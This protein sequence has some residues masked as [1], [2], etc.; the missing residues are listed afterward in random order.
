VFARNGHA[1]P[2]DRLSW[3]DGELEDFLARAG[4][5]SRVML[6][7]SLWLVAVAAP[8]AFRRWARLEALPVADRVAA[9]AALERALPEPLLAVKALLCLIYYEHPDA[10]REVGVRAPHLIAVGLH[11]PALLPGAD[12]RA[13]P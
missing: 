8:L 7:F 9:L 4:T 5:R 10:A 2:E 6:T 12:A 3:L 11:Q 1:P 13:R